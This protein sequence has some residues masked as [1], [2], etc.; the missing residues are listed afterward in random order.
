MYQIFKDCDN[1][2][3][4]FLHYLELFHIF[5]RHNYKRNHS[6]ALKQV[7]FSF[8]HIQV[9]IKIAEMNKLVLWRHLQE[10][11]RLLTFFEQFWKNWLKLVFWI[12]HLI[13]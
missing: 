6:L 5:K 11:N 7:F 1:V 4:I 10:P 13:L 8:N 2:T 9:A 3:I 12:F